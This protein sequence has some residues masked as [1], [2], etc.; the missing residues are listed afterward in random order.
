[1][2]DQHPALSVARSPMSGMKAGQ[3]LQAGS[4]GAH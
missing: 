3:G 2:A 1:M 4:A